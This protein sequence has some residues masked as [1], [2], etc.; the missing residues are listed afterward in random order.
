M[1]YLAGHADSHPCSLQEVADFETIP[2]A[3]LGKI[4]GDL[5]KHGLLVSAKGIHGGYELAEPASEITLWKICEVL[6]PIPESRSCIL[7]FEDCGEGHRCELD[8]AWLP[9]RRSFIGLLKSTT[10]GDLAGPRENEG[11]PETL[12][13]ETVEDVYANYKE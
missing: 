3:Y 2:P 11:A 12:E 13:L 9:L 1:V 7:G 5:R 10:I 6:D 8:E 4:L